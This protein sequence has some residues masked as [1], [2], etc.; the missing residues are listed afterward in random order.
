MAQ[1]VNQT[2]LDGV[3]EDDIPMMQVGPPTVTHPDQVT[4]KPRQMPSGGGVAPGGGGMPGEGNE[5]DPSSMGADV[6]QQRAEGNDTDED[7][8]N[9]TKLE[10]TSRVAPR[11]VSMATEIV[12]AN[13][14][15]S[16]RI[17]VAVAKDVMEGVLQVEADR[18][19][20]GYDSGA[21]SREIGSTQ[22]SI[23]ENRIRR[24]IKPKPMLDN[25]GRQIKD[26]QGRPMYHGTPQ[27]V[28]ERQI[29]QMTQPLVDR[30][31]D[32]TQKA[33]DSFRGPALPGRKSP[34]GKG[35]PQ[36]P[37]D[38]SEPQHRQPDEHMDHR[39]AD[40][41]VQ[42]YQEHMEHKTPD[43]L[44]DWVRGQIEYFGQDAARDMWHMRYDPS[45]GPNSQK[46][47]DD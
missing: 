38:Q 7:S 23:L 22:P 6:D 36:E 1:P 45:P 26:S 37:Q 5:F 25:Q 27:Q 24:S 19:R 12:S 44:G 31:K 28:M 42:P 39:D 15:L 40:E 2:G 29:K 4:S 33:K 41:S 10:F 8:G 3:T 9:E 13:P 32:V 46:R 11:I 20:G 21:W 47:S 18:G 14:G 35:E 16:P 17:A 34:K 30:A 43:S